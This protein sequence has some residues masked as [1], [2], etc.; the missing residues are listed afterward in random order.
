MKDCQDKVYR[1]FCSFLII[2]LKFCSLI[3]AH[4]KFNFGHSALQ[5]NQLHVK[6]GLLAS[7]RGD[8]LLQARVLG[9]LMRVVSLHFFL[10][11]KVFVGEGLAHFLGLHSQH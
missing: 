6:S 11:L 1:R 5:L 4:L 2:R 9:L 3:G 8:L 10:D 7:E